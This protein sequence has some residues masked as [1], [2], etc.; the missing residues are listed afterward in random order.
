MERIQQSR[1]EQVKQ[2]LKSLKSFTKQQVIDFAK[3]IDLYDFDV[4]YLAVKQSNAL[5]EAKTESYVFVRSESD[6]RVLNLLL[7]GQRFKIKN[8][9]LVCYF[10][11]F[12]DNHF[13][14]I[15]DANSAL[16]NY[17]RGKVYGI[18]SDCI[19][20]ESNYN[21]SKGMLL[22]NSVEFTN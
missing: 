16:G 13:L 7:S 19:I 10:N 5:F 17:I 12:I 9:D 22:F 20:V 15:I 1:L 3:S 18:E 6:E 14:H 11:R 2:Y 4:M 21:E 8:S